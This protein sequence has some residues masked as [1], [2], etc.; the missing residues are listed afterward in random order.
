MKK[1]FLR[2]YKRFKV[3][4]TKLNRSSAMKT[5]EELEL[6]EK[7]A[8]KICVKLISHEDSVFTIAPL[9]NKRYILN[10]TLN[11]FIII[12]YGRVEITNHIFHYDVKLSGRDFDRVL[13]LYDIETEKRRNTTEKEIKTNIK[14]TL[15]SIYKKIVKETEKNQ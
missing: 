13:Y 15:D 5:H 11:L 4:L 14:N 12:D 9:T 8:F 1:A 2:F 10:E 6:H 3:Y 7:T